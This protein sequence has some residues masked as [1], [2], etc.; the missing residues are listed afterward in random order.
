[1]VSP[2]PV[3]F[4]KLHIIIMALKISHHAVREGEDSLQNY[5]QEQGLNGD[6]RACGDL[7]LREG[8]TQQCGLFESF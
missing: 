5:S 8:D 2:S 4:D 1:M 6:R 3:H 7:K